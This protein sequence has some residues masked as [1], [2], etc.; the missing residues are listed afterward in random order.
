MQ[1]AYHASNVNG[2]AV[3]KIVQAA[4]A[5]AGDVAYSWDLVGDSIG[6]DG[7]ISALHG[8]DGCEVVG[9]GDANHARITPEDLEHRLN[10]LSGHF[11]AD[12]GNSDGREKT[13]TKV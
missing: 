2:D 4:L 6:W 8:L 9:T 10:G 5:G 11:T 1:V 3:S 13:S 7:D 12:M